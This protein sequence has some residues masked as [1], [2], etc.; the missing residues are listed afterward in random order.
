MTVTGVNQP[1]PL[2]GYNLFRSDRAVVETLQR[3]GAGWADEQVG[4]VGELIGGEPLV[5]GYQA[6]AH[7]PVLRSHDRFGERIDEVEF[8]PAWHAMMRFSIGHGSTRSRG[9]TDDPALTSR[10]RPCSTW[11]VT[12]KPA[13]PVRC[14]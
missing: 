8:H 7:P 14:R 3:E 2:E 11:S 6:N 13:M 9:G 12:S 10:A 4:K 1:P 5:W